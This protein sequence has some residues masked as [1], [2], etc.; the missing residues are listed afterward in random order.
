MTDGDENGRGA[1]GTRP[2]LAAAQARVR[3]LLETVRQLEE[4]RGEALLRVAALEASL[5]VAAL[6]GQIP[7][8]T[9]LAPIVPGDRALAR[10]LSDAMPRHARRGVSCRVLTVLLA[11]TEG[12]LAVNDLRDVLGT[13]QATTSAWL[14]EAVG[15]GLVVVE[16]DGFDKRRHTAKLTPKGHVYMRDRRRSPTTA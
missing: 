14:T 13:P 12:P 2:A 15:V 1:K 4:E 5:R 6:E 10:A 7:T 8:V 3:A 11:L 9:E 16:V